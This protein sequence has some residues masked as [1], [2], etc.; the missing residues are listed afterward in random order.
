M[1]EI[2]SRRLFQ[3]Q[4]F[5]ASQF[6]NIPA[7]F[8]VSVSQTPFPVQAG[9][10]VLIPNAITRAAGFTQPINFSVA[11]L[12][13]TATATLY[14]P[15]VITGPVMNTSVAI[16]A[17]APTCSYP[18]T[19]S[20]ASGGLSRSGTATISV[21]GA[22]LSISV[23]PTA[24][25]LSAGQTR[26]FAATVIGNCNAA[27]TWSISPSGSGSINGAGLYAAP[28]SIATTTTLT[29][30]ATSVV[31][32]TV[33]ASASI[34]LSAGY[35]N[36]Y[37]H[38]R[39]ITIS[40]ANVTSASQSNFPLLFSVT[41]AALASTANGGHVTSASG[42]DIVFSTDPNG[43]GAILSHELQQY[44]ATTGHVAAWVRIRLVV[45]RRYGSVRVLRKCRR[46]YL[47][48]E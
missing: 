42:Y 19:I 12:P 25:T 27:V 28:A 2:S 24:A 13:G 37:A 20:G 36:G 22:P 48:G 32:S 44:T 43:A 35:S 29:V 40:H 41:D 21:S 10:K 38:R 16:A 46:D 11:G 47:A 1:A 5:L 33:T 34:T 9:S 45:R 4:N 7:D 15:I 31:D 30:T 39:I 26:Q 3:T 23:A 14:S 8:S 18:V 17:N 6:E